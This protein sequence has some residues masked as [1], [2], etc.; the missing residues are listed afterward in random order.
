MSGAAE[1]IAG[2]ALSAISV[3]ALFT[4]CI[5]CFDIVVAGKNF[6]ED[7]E[8]LCALFSLQRARFGLWG[9]SVGLVPNP[10]G[11]KLRYDKN[12]D[13]PDIRPG[14]E[15]IL[16]NIKS[17]L[18]EAGKVDKRYG[19][20]SN[21]SEGS[22]VSTSRGL[23]IFKGSFEKFKAR[24][25][26]HQ[27]E[28][29]AWNVTR[30]AI[31]DADKFEGM[32]NRLKDFVDGLESI[33]KSLGLL[34]EQHERLRQEIESISDTQSLRLLR[35]ASS[36]HGS[37]Q[38][39]VSDAASQRLITVAESVIETQNLDLSSHLSTTGES[40]ITARSNPSGISRKAIDAGQH[41]PGAWPGSTKSAS[42]TQEEKTSTLG[43]R[44]RGFPKQSTSCEQCLEEHYKCVP[45]PGGEECSRC[46]QT[47][48]DCSLADFVAPMDPP[49]ID[50]ALT[51]APRRPS[52]E[53]LPQH[54]RLLSK[55]LSKAS[56]RKPLSFAAGDAH[57]GE[58]LA[59][60]KNED[61][62]YWLEHSGKIV[63]QAHSGSSAAKRMFFELRNIR[64]GKVPFVSAVPLDDSLAKVLASIEGPPETPYE[65]G[66]FFITV[67]LSETDP[68]APPVMRFH[69][70]I[71]HPNISPQGHIC[72]DYKEKW[73]AVLADGASKIP[74]SDSNAIWYPPRS[75]D[76]RWSLGA[77]LTALCGLLASPDVEDP[78]VPEIAQKYL[79]NYDG[80]CKN[81]SLYTKRFATG[82]RPEYQ[83]LDF[84]TELAT[85]ASGVRLSHMSKCEPESVIDNI[86]LSDSLRPIKEDT[87]F[88]TVPIR[89]LSI[90]RST[91]DA[92]RMWRKFQSSGRLGELVKNWNSQEFSTRN[93]TK[94]VNLAREYNWIEFLDVD[95]VTD[96][97]IVYSLLEKAFPP[98]ADKIIKEML[99]SSSPAFYDEAKPICLQYLADWLECGSTEVA[100]SP[101]RSGTASYQI[102]I[103]KGL[104]R[105]RKWSFEKSWLE[106]LDFHKILVQEKCV[107]FAEFLPW[108][109]EYE[110]P[111]QEDSPVV[112]AA[113]L[114]YAFA[115]LFRSYSAELLEHVGIIEFLRPQKTLEP[116]RVATP[117]VAATVE[118]VPS[119]RVVS[120]RGIYLRSFIP[121]SLIR[122]IDAVDASR[123]RSLVFVK[124]KLH[125]PFDNS[126]YMAWAIHSRGLYEQQREYSYI[127]RLMF[128]NL[129]EKRGDH[130]TLLLTFYAL[131]AGKYEERTLKLVFD[132]SAKTWL[133]FST[134]QLLIR[135][136]NLLRGIPT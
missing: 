50:S 46:V 5:E 96:L 117:S 101:L 93:V 70:K 17:L 66:I 62:K 34:Q 31:H 91:K 80:Y 110:H 129:L 8:Q 113:L 24:I 61:Q 29:S 65:G 26:K 134:L 112:I 58:R 119:S 97:D 118:T 136:D 108:T 122:G 99:L 77:L 94:I 37:S 19:L 38:Q 64:A 104:N 16:N 120:I 126:G 30:W 71:Y 57:Y 72:A 133:V 103:V 131:A 86:S 20:S 89:P 84:S 48:K 121:T 10:D 6:S 41:V 9:E 2:L 125:L 44:S 111:S 132:T 74:V 33:T 15:R 1:G 40:F 55:L 60:I 23:D 59:S 98:N 115:G 13:R 32:L 79:E 75:G 73:N 22:D 123:E 100:V 81:A 56:P 4:A 68:Y 25:K 116:L 52:T 107:P 130:Q 95:L 128:P 14:V 124:F 27:K 105:H 54:Q 49:I 53:G 35:D 87:F 42:K 88:T 11:R 12:L 83:D 39:E 92:R 90:P 85:S 135:V 18:D 76:T 67:Q 69:T 45:T 7:Y 114:Q 63:G 51:S 3:A 36:R 47:K 28:T 102:T 106:V 78:L 43:N 21:V 82:P 109:G 127:S